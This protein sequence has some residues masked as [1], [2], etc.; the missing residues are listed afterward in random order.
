MTNSRVLLT[1]LATVL[2]FAKGQGQTT[3]QPKELR[4]TQTGIVYTKET[5][6]DVY[7]HTAGMGFGMKFGDIETYYRTSYYHIEF[8]TIRHAKEVR[9]SNRVSQ[10]NVL[11][12][13]YVYG[14]Q[15]SFFTLRA[16]MGKKRYFS[17]KAK[18]RGIAVGVNYQGGLSL[19][20]VKPYYLELRSSE[21]GE[22]SPVRSE[23][24]TSENRDRFLDRTLIEG[25]SGFFTGLEELNFIPG[26]HAKGGIHFAWGAFDEQ[27]KALELG[28]MIDVYFS[29]VPIMI[30]EDNKP[31]F[32]NLYLNL[33]FGNRK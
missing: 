8:S 31:Y 7:L 6:F 15:N 24:F 29:D 14:K 5:A 1:V 11:S 32:M 23:K 3:F 20:M 17:E 21:N 10:F 19:G 16:G 12:R 25:H 28:I 30:I 4:S 26:I 2:F 9:Q 13:P 33:Q 18:R 27:V 22:F